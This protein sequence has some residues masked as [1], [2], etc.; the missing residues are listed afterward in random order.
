MY[1]IGPT[2][3]QGKLHD[4]PGVSK[5]CAESVQIANPIGFAS[6]RLALTPRS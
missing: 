3:P 6:S 1:L 2:L 5:H 4:R